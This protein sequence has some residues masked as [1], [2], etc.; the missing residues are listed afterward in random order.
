MTLRETIEY[1]R[2]L[3]VKLW[4]ELWKDHPR[5]QELEREFRLNK[6]IGTE[7]QVLKLLDEGKKPP[8]EWNGLVRLR[9]LDEF[10]AENSGS[11]AT[12]VDTLLSTL[13]QLEDGERYHLYR[14]PQGMRK[15]HLEGK[16]GHL[17]NW[18]R[19]HWVIP[20]N[21]SRYH[22]E[23]RKPGDYLSRKLADLYKRGERLRVAICH[24]E[25]GVGLSRVKPHP[26]S[27]RVESLTDPEARWQTL[28]GF[29][30]QARFAGAHVLVLP[31]LTVT[32]ALRERVQQWLEEHFGEHEMLMVL[33]GSFHEA[34]SEDPD[35]VFNRAELLDAYGHP[36]LEH[37]KLL[38]F[39]GLGEQGAED[40]HTGKW[41]RLMGLPLGMLAMPI[42][43][44]F[45]EADGPMPEV[46]KNIGPEWVLVPALGDATSLR[47]HAR[48]AAQLY[49]TRGSVTVLANQPKTEGEKAP[50]FVY[51]GQKR[52]SAE[53]A[54]EPVPCFQVVE[55]D[56]RLDFQGNKQAPG[57]VN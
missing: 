14:R 19:H 47:A 40:I 38:P 21:L 29:L 2:G 41:I 4:A 28:K 9:A 18:A 54:D 13:V 26:P 36:V 33:P 44:D 53:K 10:L 8:E 7:A 39:G 50:G 32:P 37:L 12:G 27:W 46:W 45:C 17:R 3:F 11:R 30:E 23:I 5:F 35:K 20:A 6:A 56:I 34:D 24:F 25:D 42:C 52:D 16:V 31:E 49:T 22:V 1:A 57:A 51:Q 48:A 43:L 15:G 55:V